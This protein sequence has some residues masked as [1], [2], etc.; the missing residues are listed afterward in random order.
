MENDLIY[1]THDILKMLDALLQ[2]RGGGWWDGFFSD[3]ARPCPFFVD[4]PDENLVG[5]FSA[6][7]IKPGRALEFGCGHGRNAVYL[8]GQGCVIDAVDF[9]QEAIHWAKERTAT[10][11][12]TVNYRCQSVFDLKI[13]PGQYDIVYDCG[14]FHHIPPHRRKTYIDL[15]CSALRPGGSFGLVCFRPEG[16]SS[17]TDWQVYDRRSMG[18]GLGYTQERLR[19]LFEPRFDIVEIRQMKEMDPSCRLFGKAFLWTLLLRKNKEGDRLYSQNQSPAVPIRT[20]S[21]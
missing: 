5:Y 1:S 8:A 3:H 7:L 6:G 11:G 20:G 19:T 13:E 4:W 9:S 10:A 17:L 21:P 12:V 14:C 15:V 16:G 2:D 18:G